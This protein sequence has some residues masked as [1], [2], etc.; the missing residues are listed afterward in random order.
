MKKIAL[1]LLCLVS[2]MSLANPFMLKKKYP[3]KRHPLH[4]HLI[5]QSLE[6]YTNFSGTWR[7]SCVDISGEL[8]DQEIVVEQEDAY[9]ITIDGQEMK[10]GGL[11]TEASSSS[12]EFGSSQ[13]LVNWDS[14]NQTLLIS[15]VEYSGDY[16]T[17]NNHNDFFVTLG[18]G[19][20]RLTKN[21]LRL[22]MKYKGYNEGEMLES[23]S[24]SCTL[25]K[26]NA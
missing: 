22:D 11:N 23:Q 13:L 6:N 26:V 21:E 9:S 14:H 7:G 19:T 2:T 8:F 18:S 10:I 1:V 12:D 15:N 25:T 24:M 17:W 4:Q 3:Y 20:M 16:G 5:K